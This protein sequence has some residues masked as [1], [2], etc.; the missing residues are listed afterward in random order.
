M[1]DRSL[2][3]P[4]E[5]GSP[6]LYRRIGIP[7]E[8]CATVDVDGKSVQYAGD[9]RMGDLRG[10]GEVDFL[11]Y[12]SVDDA[13]DGGGM[14]PCF[15]AALTMEGEALWSVGAGGEQP[16]RP[17][18]VAVHDIDGDG[19]AEVVCL[20]LDASIEAAP[21]SME[22]VVIQIRDGSTGALRQ[23]TSPPELRACHGQ[24][25]NW[26]HQRLLV[27]N[28]R[29][30]DR[31]RDLVV[32]LGSQVI[33]FDETLRILWIYENPWT[34]YGHCPAYIPAVGDIDG[35]GRDEVNGGYFLLDHDGTVLWERQLAQHM[36]SVAITEWDDHQVRAICSGFGHVMD[37][38][39]NVVLC[40]GQ[41]A[42]P[43]GQEVRV[44][45]FSAND[46]SPQMVIRYNGHEPDVIVVDTRGVCVNRFQL[47]VST[48]NTGME[49]VYWNGLDQ[50]ALLYNG[51]KLWNPTE[52]S[53]VGLPDLPS[54]EPVGRMAWYH[55]IPANVCGDGREE[56]VLYNPW[57]PTIF[58]YTPHPLE[59]AA[60]EGFRPEARQYNA[61][62]IA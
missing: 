47:N 45:R 22:N 33:A 42:V 50:P 30:T 6:I 12:R 35:D 7:Q 14:K 26:A 18:P 34:E 3:G 56:L 27:A 55:C 20:F 16:T 52:G 5:Y 54:P 15:M 2:T 19:C 31:P 48:N 25:A 59:S 44:A 4:D 28:F 60:F 57:D 36:D 32:K 38:K 37:H 10:T 49:A 61:R 39:G 1:T 8:L 21:T 62:L 29:G 17:G 58:I 23:Q 41:E 43:H 11:V 13:H 24:G 51:G 46:P 53:C 9:V 40:L